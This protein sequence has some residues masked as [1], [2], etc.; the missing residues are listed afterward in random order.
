MLNRGR[1]PILVSGVW[2][3]VGLLFAMSGFLLL[4]GPA[5]LTGLHEQ[6]RLTWLLGQTKNLR[7]LEEGW[8]LW[9][10]LWVLYFALV[11][12]GAVLLLRRRRRLTAIYNV[13]PLVFEEG[14]VHALE[15][16][17]VAWM[18]DG[19]YRLR[20]GVQ[21][22]GA[23][24]APNTWVEE[25][26]VDPFPALCH[27]TLKWSKANGALRQ[28]VEA[29]LARVLAGVY[30]RRNPVG[31]WFLSLALSLFLLLFTGLFVIVVLRVLR[32]FS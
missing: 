9:I 12:S 20:L 10:V 30:T 6:W 31:T 25:L 27:V 1:H 4:G 29:E 23:A 22:A 19:P 17:G 7:E 13:D 24:K 14:L 21:A 3:C 8:P 28:E 11:L 5:I 2:D 15:R 32:V 16:S 18:R 26:R